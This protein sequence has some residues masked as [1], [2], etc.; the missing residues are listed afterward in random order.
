MYEGAKQVIR[1]GG[2]SKRVTLSSGT[3]VGP[4]QDCAGCWV[5]PAIANTE[6]VRMSMGDDTASAILGV[7][8]QRPHIN[9]G[10]DE[11]GAAAAQPLWVPVNNLNLLSFYSADDDAIV[12]IMYLKG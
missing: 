7:D 9:D 12:D 3:G 4:S 11:Y 10:T 8:L 2:G 6:V 1:S 5:Q